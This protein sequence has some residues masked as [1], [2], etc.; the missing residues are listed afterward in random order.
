METGLREATREK[1]LEREHWDK[2]VSITRLA[3]RDGQIPEA[4]A[5][6]TM[7]LIPESV[8]GYRGIGLVKVE[9]IQDGL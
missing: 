9:I 4:L 3:F 6:M 1:D 7:V 5:R 8:G 2:L